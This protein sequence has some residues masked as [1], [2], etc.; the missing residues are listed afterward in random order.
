VF[1]F[2]ELEPALHASPPGGAPAYDTEAIGWVTWDEAEHETYSFAGKARI[3]GEGLHKNFDSDKDRI[4]NV[5][6]EILEG[7]S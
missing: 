4:Y 7:S 6:V 2:R 1:S 5:F 3:T